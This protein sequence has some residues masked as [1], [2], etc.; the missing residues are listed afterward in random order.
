MTEPSESDKRLG[1]L[2]IK[3]RLINYQQLTHALEFQTKL[4]SNNRI[5]I[6]EI[7]IQFGLINRN[8]LNEALKE[9]EELNKSV[10]SKTPPPPPPPN[11]ITENESP[12]SKS[13]GFG[14][15]PVFNL[16]NKNAPPPPPPKQ[17]IQEPEKDLA[18]RGI[19]KVSNNI[20]SDKS[21]HKPIGEMLVEKGYID[22]S[23]LSKALQYQSS[24]PPT[25]FKPI[26]EV[27]IDLNYVTREQLESVLN[28]QAPPNKNS[29]GEILKQLG[30]I[31]APQLAMV[32]SQEYSI[33]GKSVM[34]G[35]LLLQHGF[36]TKAQLDLALEEQRK[37]S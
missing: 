28:V 13:Q 17:N 34:T 20:N 35:E 15:K 32:L 3:K 25:H 27:L 8:S 14:V 6:G 24:L 19:P 22:K 12:F 7:L 31:D 30:I 16:I 23:Q 21:K 2:L 11:T 18:N 9:Q 37:R 29:I 33:G 36:I 1:T 4:I 26:G 10:S 5:P